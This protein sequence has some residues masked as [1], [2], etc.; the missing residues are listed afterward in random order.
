MK[1]TAEL[2]RKYAN[3]QCNPAEQEA[4]EKWLASNDAT[5]TPLALTSSAQ[6][7]RIWKNIAQETKEQHIWLMRENNA[8]DMDTDPP[9]TRILPLFNKLIKYAAAACILLTVF[10]AGRYSVPT[11]TAHPVEDKSP[12]NHLY[13]QGENGAKGNLPGEAF[14]I[15]FNGTISLFNSSLKPKRIQVGE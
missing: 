4:V 11:A 6:E 10:F 13:I 8:E 15:T 1:V 5:E 12:Q 2:L 14:N 7:D 3:Q 9:T